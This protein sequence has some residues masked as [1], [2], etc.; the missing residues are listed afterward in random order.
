ML[1][2]YSKCLPNVSTILHPLYKLLG[3]DVPWKWGKDQAKA[4]T[5]SK[6][7]LTSKSCLTHFDSSLPLIL[8][9]D[10]S[11]YGLGAVLSHWMPDGSDR[12]IGYASRTLPQSKQ[13]YSQLEK[14][15]LS[16]IFGINK[17]H[18]YVFGRPFQ[19]ITDHKPL[20]GL[21]RENKAV[22]P[23][24]SD[25]VKCWSLFLSSYEY[26]LT[27]RNTTAHANADALS[28]LPLPEEPAKITSEPEL[29][30]LAEH[31]DDSPVTAADIRV[32]TKKD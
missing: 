17:F 1:T 16:C 8:A 11:A 10:A 13:N 31:L 26:T 12:P 28:R 2:Y 24:A 18:H 15:G 9:C 32:W 3:K 30:L 7:L 6:E 23:Q 19:L 25:K 20:L 4:F 21:L 14:E 5:A 29:V 27:F 22:S